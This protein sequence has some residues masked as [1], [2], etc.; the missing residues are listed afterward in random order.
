MIIDDA[1]CPIYGCR[2][3]AT[4]PGVTVPWGPGMD[5][6]LALA[7]TDYMRTAAAEHAAT[8]DKGQFLAE[9]E[10][11]KVQLD[12]LAANVRGGSGLTLLK[13][14]ARF[15]EDQLAAT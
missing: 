3:Q 2:W 8:H 5:F 7:V 15:E 4:H 9:I 1:A 10:A 12:G 14:H 11:R 6:R 13:S